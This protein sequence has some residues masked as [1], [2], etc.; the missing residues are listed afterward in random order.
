MKWF[1]KKYIFSID[2][3]DKYFFNIAE[4]ETQS[5]GVDSKYKI[6]I[7]ERIEG[8]FVEKIEKTLLSMDFKPPFS[9]DEA[10]KR[11][12]SGHYYVCAENKNSEIIGWTWVGVNSVLFDEFNKKLK[13]KPNEAFSYNTYVRKDCRGGKINQQMKAVIVKHLK[14]NGIKRIWGLVHHWNS[15]SRKSI[16][17][18]GWVRS[19]TLWHMKIV[20]LNFN[21]EFINE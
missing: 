4:D 17:N 14:Q 11:L 3:M 7:V 5:P 9:V 15:S 1:F 2:R 19:G 13:I 21:F 20:F 6:Y 18:M 10:N 8:D 16:E 12:E